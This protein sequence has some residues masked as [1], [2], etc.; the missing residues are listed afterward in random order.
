MLYSN[1]LN[2]VT[3]VISVFAVVELHFTQTL[4]ILLMGMVSI[5]GVFGALLAQCLIR[6]VSPPPSAFLN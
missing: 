5:I 1:G 4:L 3:A 2:A 6:C